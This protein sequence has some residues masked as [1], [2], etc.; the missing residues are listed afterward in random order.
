MRS[1]APQDEQPQVPKLA[2]AGDATLP[3]L[4][5]RLLQLTGGVP[6]AAV[7]T[8]LVQQLAEELAPH[9]DELP[10]RYFAGKVP[11]RPGM[12]G[13]LAP[14]RRIPHAV[15]MGRY[16]LIAPPDA[17]GDYYYSYSMVAILAL[18]RDGVLR[19]GRGMEMIVLP[20][21]IELT[22]QPLRWD[23]IRL[24]NCP[25]GEL[26]MLRWTGSPMP[27]DVGTASTVLE[28]M[29]A[30]GELVAEQSRHDL[31]LLQRLTGRL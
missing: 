19:I 15:L 10:S 21:D 4:R 13:R 20:K 18:G 2:G 23:D 11:R 28:A 5:R 9:F 17:H 27:E 14:A 6:A 31:N 16:L 24:R 8:E 25:T 3:E 1:Q 29:I 7:L 30:L 26:R 12:L 22:D